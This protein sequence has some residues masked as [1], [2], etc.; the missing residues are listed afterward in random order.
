MPT[1]VLDPPPIELQELLE[2][3]W[4]ADIRDEVWEGVLHMNPGPDSRHARLQVHVMELL[5]PLAR[6]RVLVPL[7][8]FN[9]GRA[10]DYRI[11][12]GGLVRPGPDAVYKPTAALVL[13]VVS[14]GDETWQKLQ[15]YAAHEVDEVLIVDADKR[16]VDWLALTAA[17]YRPAERSALI[18]LSRVDL[19]DR[20]DWPT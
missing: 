20:I 18:E 12:D 11:P 4:G 14:P 2:R 16:S 19:T 3:R 10:D 5:G 15:F 9:L 1:L 13:E 17:E 6:A 7:G 8:N